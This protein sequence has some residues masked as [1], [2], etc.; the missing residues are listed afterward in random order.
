MAIILEKSQ[1]SG[2]IAEL[3]NGLAL[4]Y[5]PFTDHEII[6]HREAV[7]LAQIGKNDLVLE[8]ACGTGRG[9]LEIAKFTDK[10]IIAMDLSEKM[11]QKAE[12]KI[13][14]YHLENKIE[15][16]IGNAREL[17]FQ[18]NKFD[19]LYNSYMFDLID[20]SEMPAVIN[21]FK[22]V[23]KPDGKLVLVN[24][25]KNREQKILYEKLYEKGILNFISG[26]CRPVMMEPFVKSSGFNN[27]KRV[28]RKNYSWFPIN[29][30]F[31]TEIIT[32]TNRIEK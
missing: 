25:S 8:V 15:I 27:I 29:W 31:G 1:F 10:K 18:D 4:L 26:S 21:E 6:H 12:R 7:R 19:V 28:Y 23:L 11:L 22:R 9:F 24:L 17:P 3:Y 32:A 13:K 5:D 14:K 2:K 20:L 30:M 16:T